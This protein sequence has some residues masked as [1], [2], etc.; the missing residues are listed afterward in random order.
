MKLLVNMLFVIFSLVMVVNAANIDV[1]KKLSKLTES[2]HIMFFV[3]IPNCSYCKAMLDENLKNKEILD[4]INKNFVFINIYTKDEGI[5]SFKDFK[6]TYKEFS[7]YIGAV[8]YPATI[9]MDNSGKI[10]YRSIGYRNIKEQIREIKYIS[11]GSYKKISL[12]T[13]I[14]NLEME[15]FDEE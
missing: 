2:K 8:A 7:R 11:S 13:F 6:G 4:V 10:I 9:F 15:E 12:E 1:N 3:H 5:V 14:E